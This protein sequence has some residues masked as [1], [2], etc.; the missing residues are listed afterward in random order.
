VGIIDI[1]H[2]FWKQPPRR[3]AALCALRPS[4]YRYVS[5]KQ[6]MF[7]NLRENWATYPL[8]GDVCRCGNA[9]K[10]CFT[11]ENE[12]IIVIFNGKL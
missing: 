2:S 4:V 9:S 5:D 8:D 3:A 1:I 12:L 11:C 10:P 6:I 7:S